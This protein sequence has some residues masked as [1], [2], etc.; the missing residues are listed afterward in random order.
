[1]A[2]QAIK[3]AGAAALEERCVWSDLASSPVVAGVGYT[4]A[5]RRSLTL[6]SSEGWWTKTAWAKVAGHTCTS[7][8][9]I[10]TS[11][12]ARVVLARG[13]GESLE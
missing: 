2:Q 12:G 4:E 7:I 8:P 5:V 10:Q 13:A 1:M 9:A 3:I 6:R 11:T